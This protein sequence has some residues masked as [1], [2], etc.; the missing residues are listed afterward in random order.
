MTK[1]IPP[2]ARIRLAR[3]L[4]RLLALPILGAAPGD[5]RRSPTALLLLPGYLALGFAAAGLLVGLVAIA[6]AAVLL[7]IHLDVEESE[8]IV[9][10]LGRRDTY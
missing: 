2:I 6:G 9:A 7:S 8:V 3:S 1:G 4:P 5:G 10:R